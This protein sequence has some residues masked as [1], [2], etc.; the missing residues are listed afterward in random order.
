L[1]KEKKERK[2]TSSAAS[3]PCRLHG[4][5]N[6]LNSWKEKREP[7]VSLHENQTK[8]TLKKRIKSLAAYF[9]GS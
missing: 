2:K 6:T 7:T 4:R 9:R 3:L 5:S 1:E 8:L